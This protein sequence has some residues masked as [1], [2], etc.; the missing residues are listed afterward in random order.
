VG[1]GEGAGR[2]ADR[3]ARDL[4]ARIVSGEIP[5]GSILPREA[6]LAVHFRVNRSVVREA[7]KLLEVHRLVEPVRRRGTG[8]LDP[9]RS[10]SPDVLRAMLEPRAGRID[11]RVLRSLLEIRALLDREMGALAAQRRT[12]A[13]LAR[14]DALLARLERELPYPDRYSQTVGELAFSVARATGN[15]IFEMMVAWNERVV[16]DLDHV[17]RLTR[18]ATEP[19]LGGLKLMVELIRRRDSASVHA[20]TGAFHDWATPRLVT[21]AALAS[22]EP[23]ELEEEPT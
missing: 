11:R 8:V 15:P 6:D 20:L 17:F 12:D 2:K 13:D 3:V 19:H 22:G 7:V 9:V 4:M 16:A 14:M 1:E 18:P 21:A 5:V 10:L 23:L